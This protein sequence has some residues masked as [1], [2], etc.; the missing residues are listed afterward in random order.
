MLRR[1]VA[2]SLVGVLAGCQSYNF[3]PVGTCYIQ[4]GSTRIQL[5]SL[6]TADMWAPQYTYTAP[7]PGW[8]GSLAAWNESFV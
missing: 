8:G 1:L 5:S 4:P 2:C 6:A 3:S 7:A